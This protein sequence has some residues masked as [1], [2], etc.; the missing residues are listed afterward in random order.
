MRRFAPDAAAAVSGCNGCTGRGQHRSVSVERVTVSRVRQKADP[1]PHSGQAPE[2]AATG[3][4]C[5]LYV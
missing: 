3:M 4:I 5:L 2:T 1:H